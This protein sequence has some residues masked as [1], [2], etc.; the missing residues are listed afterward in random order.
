[1]LERTPSSEAFQP[2]NILA[3]DPFAVR[4]QV[5][6]PTM[7]TFAVTLDPGRVLILGRQGSD[8]DLELPW[9]PLVSRRHAKLWCD[10]GEIW[11]EDLLSKNGSW[12]GAR[13]LEGPVSLATGSRVILGR[14]QI[15]VPADESPSGEGDPT[16]ESLPPLALAAP[17]A[18]AASEIV[19]TVDLPTAPTTTRN[20]TKPRHVGTRQVQIRVTDPESFAEL[21]QREIRRGGVYVESRS[22]PPI[23]SQLDVEFRFR[24]SETTIVG[25]VVTVVRQADAPCVGLAPGFAVELEGLTLE[26][27]QALENFIRNDAPAPP[28]RP[29]RQVRGQIEWTDIFERARAFLIHAERRAF[30]D[31]IGVA[32]TAEPEMIER[33][34]ESLTTL[35][36]QAEPTA[37]PPRAARLSAALSVLA[38]IRR[39]LVEPESRLAYDFQIGELRVDARKRAAETGTGPDRAT[40]RRIYGLHFPDRAV[41]AGRLAQAAFQAR[42]L[43][44]LPQAVRLGER[45]LQFDPFFFELEAALNAWRNELR[46]RGRSGTQNLGR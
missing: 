21:W 36:R 7:G 29:P 42:Q 17:A 27:R 26:R 20:P 28:S 3:V 8:V 2:T 44:D 46:I 12:Q 37:P 31:A 22:P 5:V 35:F 18:S 19:G 15:V 9:D 30:Y 24:D 10:G 41:N 40:L 23:G 11:F 14:T 1:M 45:A 34:L 13:R 6:H 33:A 25:R 32:R 43:L 16:K 38:R 39:V 4:V